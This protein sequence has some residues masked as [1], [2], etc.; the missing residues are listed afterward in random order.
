MFVEL[1]ERRGDQVAVVNGVSP[2]E[3]IVT[4]GQLK[5]RNGSRLNINNKVQPD[6]SPNPTPAN[7]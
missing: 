3:E 4:S 1:G 2:G 6:N 5:L 7:K